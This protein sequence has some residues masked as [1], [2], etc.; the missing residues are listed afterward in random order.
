MTQ[1][2]LLVML[3]ANLE[4][5][6]D[7]M[8]AEAQAAKDAELMVYITSA[9]A[10]IQREGIDL[11]IDDDG[12]IAEVSDALLVL[13]YAGWLYDKR[14]DPTAQMPVMLR[15]NMNN[16]LFAQKAQETT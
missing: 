10:Y 7:Y 1:E 3:K 2:T 16:R 8:D 15:W 6:T 4:I 5:I 11:G 14:K 12:G 13:M 9:E